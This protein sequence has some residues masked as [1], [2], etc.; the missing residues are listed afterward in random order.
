MAEPSSLQPCPSAALAEGSFLTREGVFVSLLIP[1]PQ[2]PGKLTLPRYNR[3]G[4][5]SSPFRGHS[6]I[7][8]ATQWSNG[9]ACTEHG[10][11]IPPPV[12]GFA[13]PGASC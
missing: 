9:Q 1:G 2:S 7:C 3:E 12:S 4:L 10:L 5:S 6:R 8:F 13:K 11:D